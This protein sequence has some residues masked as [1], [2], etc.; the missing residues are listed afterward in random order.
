MKQVV[1]TG[2]TG[3]IGRNLTKYLALKN[4][5]VY[6]VVRNKQSNINTISDYEN[7][8]I[9][10]CDLKNIQ[11]I[12]SKLPLN[13]D[14][15]YHFA[16][17]G[18]YK[19]HRSNYNI[20]LDNIASTAKL[21]EI[22]AS[23]N[24]KKFIFPDSLIGNECLMYLDNN[25]LPIN[26]NNIYGLA[27]YMANK[28]NRI[29]AS[30]LNIEYISAIISNVYG[31]DEKSTRLICSMIPKMLKEEDVAFTL[32][33]Q[34][35]DFIYI[36]DAIKMF[37]L[38]GESGKPFKEYYIGNAIQRPLKEFLYELKEATG[39]EKSLN[40]GKIPFN[41]ISV[42]YTKMD[43]KSIENDFGFKAKIGF[44]EGIKK[45]IAYNNM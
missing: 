22:A 41:G 14:V 21:L 17:E 27:K 45:T 8:E 1:I 33:E 30:N 12:E 10:Y 40:L 38:I 26:I 11:E 37:Y 20:Q 3:Y 35:Y 2:A 44:K 15:I 28:M 23:L 36:D 9:I 34:L 39:Y 19:E 24:I 5:K 7:V 6:A 4:I 32:G 18:L 13:I 31:G 42:D 29:I 16:W 43:T 25:I